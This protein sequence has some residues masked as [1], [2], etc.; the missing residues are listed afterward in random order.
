MPSTVFPPVPHHERL[1]TTTES[2]EWADLPIVDLS[3]ADT[4]EGRAQLA[5][6]VRD[7][8]S[9]EGFFY[10]INHGLTQAQNDR[11][12]DIADVPFSLV[13]DDE[14]KIYTGDFEKT[15]VYLGYKAR[16]HWHI[17]GGVRDQIEQYNMDR[18]VSKSE[19]PKA[20]R[21]FLPEIDAFSRYCHYDILNPILR[22]LALGLELPEETFVNIHGFEDNNETAIRFMKYF[23]RSEK[24][25]LITENVWLKGHTDIGSVSMLFSQPISAL[26]MLSPDGKWR[27]VKHIDHALVINAGDVMEFLSGGFYKATI[28]RVVQPPEDQRG[29]PR[30]GV[31]YFAKA[32]DDVKLVPFAESPLLQ[33]VGIKRLCD[34]ADAPTMLEWR[35]SRTSA[36][37]LTKLEKKENNI[38]EE[39]II[40]V[41]VKHY[42]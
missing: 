4:P 32:N 14:K 1:S 33:R 24:E 34:D 17:N 6:R 5:L 9:K 38:E 22:L 25:E 13:G 28:H 16:Q 19:H 27:W 2:L 36:Y 21:P 23:P 8:M 35:K 40:G 26:Q 30:V 42:N 18:D 29:Y 31:F 7:A 15:G 12:F 37:G 10:V 3:K 41:V 39:V 20:L 11:M